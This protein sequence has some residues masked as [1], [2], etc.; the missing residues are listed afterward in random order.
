MLTFCTSQVQS[1]FLFVQCVSSTVQ[2]CTLGYLA[3]QFTLPAVI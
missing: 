3:V 1:N 2:M